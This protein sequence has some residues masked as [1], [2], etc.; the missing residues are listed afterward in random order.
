MVSPNVLLLGFLLSGCSD[1]ENQDEYEHRLN[2]GD[3]SPPTTFPASKSEGFFDWDK[4]IAGADLNGID[5]S[6]VSSMREQYRK[7]FSKFDSIK[8]YNSACPPRS[9]RVNGKEISIVS[10]SAAFKGSGSE[11]FRSSDKKILFKTIDRYKSIFDG[12][13]REKA[14]LSALDSMKGQTSRTYQIETDLAFKDCADRSIIFDAVGDL[15]GLGLLTLRLKI[16]EV[17]VARVGARMIELIRDV[18]SFGIVHGDVH[19]GNFVFDSTKDLAE[20][21]KIIDFGRAIPF[22]NPESKLHVK[23]NDILVSDI[24]T[25]NPHLLSPFEIEGSKLS[26]RDDM[27]RL[28]EVLY[29]LLGYQRPRVEFWDMRPLEKIIKGKRNWEADPSS[30]SHQIFTEFH[31]EMVNLGFTDRPDY[32]NWINKF[33]SFS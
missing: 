5:F 27:Y 6:K 23:Q 17:E 30:P 22:I 11:I 2:G 31:H 1:R 14:V 28:A 3:H 26:R 21:V 13:T 10:F 24:G 25:L 15:S 20:T 29:L 32:E 18:H 16:S 7:E 4:G 8:W 19:P 33:S 9:I 12:L